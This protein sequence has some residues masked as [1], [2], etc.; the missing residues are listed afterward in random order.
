MQKL[1]MK[2][3]HCM[4]PQVPPAVFEIA[5]EC[6]I[7]NEHK[8]RSSFSLY[9]LRILILTSINVNHNLDKVRDQITYPLPNWDGCTLKFR[10]GFYNWFHPTVDTGYDYLSVSKRTDSHAH[11]GKGWVLVT[12]QLST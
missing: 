6:F 7:G 5:D 8:T 4:Y 12:C 3:N 2:Q 11:V 10:N 9:V 1:E